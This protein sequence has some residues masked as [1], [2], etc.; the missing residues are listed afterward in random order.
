MKKVYVIVSGRYSD[1]QINAIF[2]REELANKFISVMN[3]EASIK[4]LRVEVW[5]L[6]PLEYELVHGEKAYVVL[7]GKDGNVSSVEWVKSPYG[8]GGSGVVFRNDMMYCYCFAKD[9]Q[10]AIKISNE[11]R[12]QHI[13]NNTWGK[14]NS[15]Q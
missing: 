13:A 11:K 5:D 15:E 10:H 2:D 7:I 4:D 8:F 14:N 6:N 3:Y 1:Y 9:E 12:A